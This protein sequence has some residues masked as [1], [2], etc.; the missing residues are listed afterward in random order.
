MSGWIE[1]DIAVNGLRLHYYRSGEAKPPLVFVHGFTD[2]ALYWTRLAEALQAD[3]EVILYDARGHGK[4]DRTGGH[5]GDEER[6]GDLVG[7][8]EALGIQKP[9]LI[10]HSMGGAT[11]AQAAAWH[12]GLARAL[13]LEDPALYELPID[14]TSETENLAWRQWVEGLQAGPYEAGL[15][16]IKANNPGWAPGDQVLSYNARRQMETALFDFYPLKQAPWHDVMSQIDC[17]VLLLIGDNPQRSAIITPEQAQE[18]ARLWRR[19]RWVQ[20]PGA[21]HSIRYDQF[22]RYLSEV[23]AFLQLV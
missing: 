13:V 17:P 19:G 15:E 2:N 5:F 18:M 9:A 3:W 8:L 10:G 4:S 12:P 23:K 7:F 22:E 11:I 16:Q 20:I 1:D 14:L 21:G 6:V